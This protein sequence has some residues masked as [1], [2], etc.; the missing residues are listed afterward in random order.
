MNL[1]SMS[2][3]WLTL[4][5]LTLFSVLS[6]SQANS[7]STGNFEN[8]G[9]IGTVLHPGSVAYDAAKQSYTIA[10]S[11]ENMWFDDDGFQ[12]A[13]RRCPAM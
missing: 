3:L 2:W 1:K 6:L 12:F 7:P 13:G 8:H 11:G 5:A 4:V 10:G 9:D